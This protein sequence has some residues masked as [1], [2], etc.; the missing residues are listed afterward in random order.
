MLPGT[1]VDTTEDGQPA[2]R[3]SS[4]RSTTARA[5]PTRRPSDDLSRQSRS[6]AC[7]GPVGCVRPG[8]GCVSRPCAAAGPARA[9]RSARCVSPCRAARATMPCRCARVAASAASGSRAST[10]SM[11]AMCSGADWLGAAGV[12]GEAELVA[13]GLR[14][15]PL[16]QLGRGG[17]VAELAD[18]AVEVLVQPRVLDEVAGCHGRLRSRRAA[19][20][21]ARRPASVRFSAALRAHSVSSPMRTSTISTASSTLIARTR[22]P[23]LGTRSTSPSLVR[24]SS[25]VRTAAREASYRSLRSASIRR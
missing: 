5:T 9:C 8:R 2:S 13:R 18:A 22:A 4:C 7:R 15:Q 14:A 20:A 25:A 17:V 3:R 24:L 6:P 16:Q 21:A 23:R 11:M 1:S 19:V 10:A 12:E